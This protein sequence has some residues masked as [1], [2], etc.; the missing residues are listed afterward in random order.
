LINS[1][2]FRRSFCRA[3]PKLKFSQQQ[4]E[5]K[6]ETSR[7]FSNVQ[8]KDSDVIHHIQ[9][10]IQRMN[11]YNIA[12]LLHSIGKH[13][14]NIE[15]RHVR[16]IG[17]IVVGKVWSEEQLGKVFYGMRHM[18]YRNAHTLVEACL[19]VLEPLQVLH[20]SFKP[21][22]TTIASM[23]SGLR[24][25]PSDD[26]HVRRVI[27][28]LAHQINTC[29]TSFSPSEIAACMSGF[30]MM[31][32]DQL[33]VSQLIG[34]LDI[35]VQS[36]SSAFT[37]EVIGSC[38]NMLNNF[39]NETSCVQ[40]LVNT[41]S[42][43]IAR[44]KPG[45][46]PPASVALCVKGLAR[47]DN[48]HSSVNNLLAA[49][50]DQVNASRSKFTA[51]DIA[52]CLFGMQ[53]MCVDS[54]ATRSLQLALAKQMDGL[55]FEPD[56]AG[57]FARAL[58]GLQC[59]SPHTQESVQLLRSLTRMI[60]KSEHI[61]LTKETI[62]EG[63]F[64]L[65]N[66]HHSHRATLDL[67]MAVT[68]KL[69]AFTGT[70][71]QK[72]VASC[73]FG[74]RGMASDRAVVKHAL[75]VLAEI[76]DRSPLRSNEAI[77]EKY[78][79]Q[80]FN[81]LQNMSSNHREVNTL[82]NS[83]NNF[84][85]KF[86]AQ[87]YFSPRALA[88]AV[89]GLQA[90]DSSPESMRSIGALARHISSAQ[91]PIDQNIAS[92]FYGLQR[93]DVREP[94]VLQVL[95]VLKSRWLDNFPPPSKA[96]C[97]LSNASMAMYGL[98]SMVCSY[99]EA[100]ADNSDPLPLV[101]CDIVK[102]CLQHVPADLTRLGPSKGLAS[103]GRSVLFLSHFASS[104]TASRFPD[105]V[106]HALNALADQVPVIVKNMS[107]YRV[108]AKTS[109]FEKA[110][111]AEIRSALLNDSAVEKVLTATLLQGFEADIIV[112]LKEGVR[113]GGRMINIEIDGTHH[114]LPS[115]RRFCHLRDKYL[116][117]KYGVDVRRIDM[118]SLGH[119]PTESIHE[120]AREYAADLMSSCAKQK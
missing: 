108:G 26:K 90:I 84:F 72:A 116:R 102:W 8:V 18:S 60:A 38:V 17:E 10:N 110:F 33:E 48:A 75:S 43:V 57:E 96:P 112:V 20:S 115:K 44:V 42:I 34:A 39:K 81:G 117:E 28:I 109:R 79:G 15:A 76:I 62:G 13:R 77:S 99:T 7:I 11:A 113:S 56:E 74:M 9:K 29:N 2:N 98:A 114:S 54:K 24:L 63:I 100:N 53:H 45:T 51:K 52:D 85:F 61:A 118:D 68:D 41:W 50:A 92:V 83:L 97:S 25:M 23:L 111:A 101:V 73:M 93:M 70:L 27:S 46:F 22:P 1:N 69:M 6:N 49:L 104:P 35:K 37:P 105:D 3:E 55:H 106:Q 36:S 89:F 30:I 71:D 86:G 21:N 12:E 16:A 66:L 4:E 32:T 87:E 64:G 95:G 59:I 103:C 107:G 67:L 65:Q 5:L 119:L 88:S 31:R 82:I 47:M 91:H 58:Y 94:D 80:A 14:V 40:N 120:F 78:V 19:R